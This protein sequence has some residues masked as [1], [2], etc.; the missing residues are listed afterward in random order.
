MSVAEAARRV[1]KSTLSLVP[2]DLVVV[3]AYV[4]VAT[5]AVGTGPQ[6]S[7]GQFLVGVGLVL[8]APGYAVVAALFPGRPRPRDGRSPTSL[9]ALKRP[10]DGVLFRER[11][12]L[13]FGVS[14]LLIPLF[15]VGLG[16]VGV[17]LTTASTLGVV[18]VVVVV[19]T[20]VAAVRRFA[21]PEEAR[22][23]LPSAAQ[24]V[25]I[26]RPVAEDSTTTLLTVGL[27]CVVVLA[28]GSFAAAVAGPS[29]GMSYTSASLLTTNASG[30][31]VA[32]GYPVNASRGEPVPLVVRVTNHHQTAQNYTVVARLQR[33]DGQQ[34][35][36]GDP[37]WRGQRRLG[38]NETWTANHTVRPSMAGQNLRLTYF[39]YRGSVPGTVDTTTADR[40]LY[41]RLDVF[42][43]GAASPQSTPGTTG[44]TSQGPV[45]A[46]G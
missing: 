31:P 24:Q 42:P 4:G 36:S 12:A 17:R 43:G 11:L 41:L 44:T 10:H 32:S 38:A 3:L 2:L 18:W 16:A 1:V 40:V 30:D 21:L 7:V 5:A 22:F 14:V 37:A 27:C 45:S 13:A 23:D 20:V 8:F 35:A 26:E 29:Q 15:A 33:V 9:L 46:R 28:L 39:V 34:V 19:A 25:G 6:G